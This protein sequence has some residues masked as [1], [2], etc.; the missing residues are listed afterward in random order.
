[1]N[2]TINGEVSQRAT[3]GRRAAGYCVSLSF[4]PAAGYPVDVRIDMG[5]GDK[6]AKAAERVADAIRFRDHVEV[7]GGCVFP[8]TDHSYSAVVLTNVTALKVNGVAVP[9]R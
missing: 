3:H 8:R 2:V 5:E 4:M 6:G 7:S 9:L 1:M